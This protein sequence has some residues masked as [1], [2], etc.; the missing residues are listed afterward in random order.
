LTLNSDKGRQAMNGWHGVIVVSR[1]HGEGLFWRCFEGYYRST[2]IGI[3]FRSF[4]S[5]TS[6]CLMSTSKTIETTITTSVQYLIFHHEDSVR[7]PQTLVP[8]ESWRSQLSF[9]SITLG[10]NSD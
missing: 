5:E 4:N 9:C 7:D 10:G 1:S 6:I 8:L 3:D 2:Y